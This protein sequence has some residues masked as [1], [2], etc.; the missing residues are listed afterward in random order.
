[1]TQS[2]FAPPVIGR[3][4]AV[5]AIEAE[6]CGSRAGQRLDAHRAKS[7]DGDA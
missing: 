4:Q 3:L 1:M 6:I 2:L 7:V 5:H